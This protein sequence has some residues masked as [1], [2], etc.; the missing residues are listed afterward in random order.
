MYRVF[1]IIILRNIRYINIG[2]KWS[3]IIIIRNKIKE[4][5]EWRLIID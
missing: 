5:I 2:Y 4:N 1:N 3:R